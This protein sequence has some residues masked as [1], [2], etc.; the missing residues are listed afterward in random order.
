M[1][2]SRSERESNVEY[3]DGEEQSVCIGQWCCGCDAH[4][5]GKPWGWNYEAWARHRQDGCKAWPE[6]R[7]VER[8]PRGSIE[9]EAAEDLLY[10]SPPEGRPGGIA[11]RNAAGA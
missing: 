4:P 6:D 2:A 5:I 7:A 11:K 8:F 1:S 9:R 3:H 10:G